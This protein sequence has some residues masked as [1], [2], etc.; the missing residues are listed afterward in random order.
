MKTRFRN[1]LAVILIIAVFCF[2]KV[3]LNRLKTDVGNYNDYGTSDYGG[4]SYGS[5][6]DYDFDDYDN[7][8]YNRNYSYDNWHNDYDTGTTYSYY[9]YDDEEKKEVPI[10]I[11]ILATIGLAVIIYFA[12]KRDNADASDIFKEPTDKVQE[13]VIEPEEDIIKK[14]QVHD[15]NFNRED[16]LKN[17][18][19]NLISV[20]DAISHNDL[21]KLSK[22][23][24]KDFFDNI[25]LKE[26]I[27][28][29]T[30]IHFKYARIKSFNIID[31]KETIEIFLRAKHKEYV[32]SKDS[33]KIIKGNIESLFISDYD[34]TLI[35]DETWLVSKICEIKK[36]KSN[37][38]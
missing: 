31:N 19:D 3:P 7:Y 8:N 27:T 32:V 13:V 15:S 35:K 34:I 11:Y 38:I 1:L 23:V 36:V 33:N 12:I 18:E 37:S 4:Y 10:Y 14:I 9:T 29:I 24:T 28:V 20:A 2:I 17:L 21:D 6:S 26:D 5:Y 25:S 22:L 30:D 16:F